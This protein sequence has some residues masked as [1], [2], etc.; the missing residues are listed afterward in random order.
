M[1]ML[2]GDAAGQRATSAIAARLS[3]S[4]DVTTIRLPDGS[5]PDQLQSRE[6]NEIL[7][8]HLR[9]AQGYGR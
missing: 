2:D 5:Q 6:I 8:G 1:L 4:I 7:S 9:E 3:A